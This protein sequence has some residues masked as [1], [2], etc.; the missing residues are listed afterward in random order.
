MP[1]RERLIRVLARVMALSERAV[2]EETERMLHAFAE[3]H[4][5][6]RAYLERRFDEV[7]HD[8][9]TDQ[10]LSNSRKL[11]I[12]AYLTLEYSLE[13]AALFNPSVV[14]HPDQGSCSACGP[15]ERG[16]SR[17]SCFGR[18]RSTVPAG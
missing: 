6:L 13:A 11:L 15:R 2:E 5:H 1:N 16:I 8:L 9:I 10:A 4:Q 17:R 12:G 18:P 7:Q 14:E 3:R